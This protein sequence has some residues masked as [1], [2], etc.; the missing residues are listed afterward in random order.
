MICPI[1]VANFLNF[2]FFRTELVFSRN[3]SFGRALYERFIKQVSKHILKVQYNCYAMIAVT[4]CLIGHRNWSDTD[5]GKIPRL[6][7]SD[8]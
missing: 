7:K 1:N 3:D 2:S 6:A 5:L 4:A 8:K